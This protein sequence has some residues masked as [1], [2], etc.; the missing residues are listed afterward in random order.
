MTETTETAIPRADWTV[1]PETGR[2]NSSERFRELVQ[3]VTRL[4]ADGPGWVFRPEWVASTAALIV[5]Q[6]AHVHHLAPTPATVTKGDVIRIVP[7]AGP[8]RVM[9][10]SHVEHHVITLA[11]LGGEAAEDGG[12]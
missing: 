2:S 8:E 6:L 12:Q 1:D 7:E 4:L 10:V 5:A 11:D 3:E 9:Q